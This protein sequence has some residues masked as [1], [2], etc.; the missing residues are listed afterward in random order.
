MTESDASEVARAVGEKLTALDDMIPS[1][2]ITLD[3]IRPGYARMSMDVR[4]DMV[5]PHGVCRGFHLFALGDMASGF[6]CCSWNRNAVAQRTDV[7]F[8]SAV[9]L[10]DRLS[11]EAAETSTV[12]RNAVYD[13][14]IVNQGGNTVTLFRCQC[15]L[16]DGPV[17]EN[18]PM[19]RQ[20]SAQPRQRIS[21]N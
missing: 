13:V 6:A 9:K 5:G 21:F 15:R 17:V 11:V 3:E 19:L 7:F 18:L 14:R 4:N 10:G 8:M 1:L 20:D 12:G 2:G 16:L